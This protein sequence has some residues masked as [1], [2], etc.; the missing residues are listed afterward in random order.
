MPQFVTWRLA[1]SLPVDLIEA[2]RKELANEEP[3]T[4]KRL[5]YRLTEQHLDKGVGS[6]ILRNPV[7]ARIVQGSLL[8][9][10][11]L[12]Y[13]LHAWSV[14]P[15]H[16]HGLFTPLPGQELSRIVQ[17]IKSFS[18]RKIHECLGGEGRLWQPDYYDRVMRDE[19]HFLKVVQYIEWNPVKAKLVTDPRH[20][21]WSSGYP[22]NQQKIL[23]N[24]RS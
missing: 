3:A 22:T 15:N 5:M 21:S 17:S 7:A 9:G 19:Q 24:H 6:C 8:F 20:F 23:D 16:V 13:Q 12:K 10:H 18:A 11:Q 14:M 2:W 4:Q 1:D